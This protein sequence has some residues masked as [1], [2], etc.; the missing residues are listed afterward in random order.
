MLQSLL[1]VI[2]MMQVSSP[3]AVQIKQLFSGEAPTENKYGLSVET[4][5]QLPMLNLTG[6]GH[7]YFH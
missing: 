6:R 7:P 4:L 1:F 5:Q 2:V 3:L